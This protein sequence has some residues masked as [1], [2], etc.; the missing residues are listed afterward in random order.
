MKQVLV[1]AALLLVGVIFSLKSNCQQNLSDLTIGSFSGAS[2]SQFTNEIFRFKTGLATHY[3]NGALPSGGSTGFGS[4]DRWLS[5]GKVTGSSQDIYGF[6][7]QVN[8]R[9]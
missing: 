8:G 5:F 9:G 1:S 3:F 6:R 7:T 4:S 2:P